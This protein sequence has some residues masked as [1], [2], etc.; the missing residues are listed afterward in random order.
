MTFDPNA[1]PCLP[2]LK[3]IKS[4]RRPAV[5]ILREQGVNG[6]V[7]MARCFHRVGFITVDVHMTDILSSKVSLSKFAG[8]ACPGGFS[9]GDV[10][11]A[12]AGWAKSILLNSHARKEFVEFF[13]RTNAFTLGVC[14]GCQ[15]LSGLKEIIPGAES[16]PQFLRNASEQFE[17]RVCTLEVLP[18]TSPLLRGMNGSRLPVAVAHGEGRAS[19]QTPSDMTRTVTQQRVCVRYVTNYGSPASPESYPLNP[20]GSPLGIAGV[21]AAEGRV[22]AMMPHPERVVRNIENTWGAGRYPWSAGDIGGWA[23]MF[24]NAR[25]WVEEVG[26]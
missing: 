13:N 7:E 5:A 8:L 4:A 15:M 11:G 24:E 1:N 2:L 3:S 9:Y 16:W 10:L 18:N 6:H 17:A 21:V 23:R 19:F 26:Y 12:G 25:L 22:V 14:N 20:N